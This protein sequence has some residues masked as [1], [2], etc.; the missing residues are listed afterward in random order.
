MSEKE[1]QEVKAL[2]AQLPEEAQ[3]EIIAAMRSLLSAKEGRNE[4]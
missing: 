1:L 2:F 4:Q 3:R